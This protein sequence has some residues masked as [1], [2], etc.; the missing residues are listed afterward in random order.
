R[1]KG[2]KKR[3]IK[4]VDQTKLFE[5]EKELFNFD[6]ETK[7]RLF[8]ELNIKGNL[9]SSR[10]IEVLGYKPTEWKINY[11]ELEVNRTNQALYNAYLKILEIEGYNE[12]LLKLSDKDDINI[13]ELKTPASE[14]KDMVKQI[15]SVLGINTEILEFDAELDGKAFE[16]QTSYQLWHLLYS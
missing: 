14:I 15:F 12:D 11:S 9:K 3:V 13:N 2:S 5:E 1:K 8:E 4:N 6:L 10:I 7:L 16:Q